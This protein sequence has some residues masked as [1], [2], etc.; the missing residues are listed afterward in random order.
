MQIDDNWAMFVEGKEVK[1]TFGDITSELQ[2][3][4]LNFLIGLGKFGQELFGEGIASI[5]FD[6]RMHTGYKTSEIFI[7]SLH[8]EFYLIISDPE[9]TL[10]LIN[11]KGGVPEDIREIMTAVLV[12]QA[13]VLYASSVDNLLPQEKESLEKHFRDIILDVNPNYLVDE[14]I[15]MIIGKSGSNFSMLSFDECLLFHFFL[16]KHTQETSY[17]TSSNW[18]LISHIDGG[19][20]PFS[21]NT[22]DDILLGGYFSAIIGL[23]DKLFESKPKMIAFGSTEV[24]RLRFVYGKR[25]FMAIDSDFL[26][27]LLLTRR[28][29]SEFFETSYSVIK[30]ISQGIK[31]LIVEEIV[32]FNE[33]YFKQ[34]T[35]ESLLDLFLGEASEELE[36]FFGEEKEN[37]ELLREERKNQVLKVIGRL[38]LDSE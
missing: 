8:E 38:L 4:I 34:Y 5:S 11:N 26:I 15:N 6:R 18:C 12:G 19:D 16:R 28:F 22:E 10:L 23:I 21:Y 27:D 32:T 24:R 3:I 9:T 25:F 36:L 1:W 35:A 13:S 7:V 20:I 31:E 2:D 30:D 14:K 37:L 33:R 17:F 29:Q